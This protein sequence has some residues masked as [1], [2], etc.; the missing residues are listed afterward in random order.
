MWDSHPFSGDLEGSGRTARASRPVCI[1]FA[2]SRNRCRD[3]GLRRR[4][5]VGVLRARGAASSSPWISRSRRTISSLR[6][7]ITL[8]SASST[9][10][11]C[12]SASKPRAAVS[13]RLSHSSA[14]VIASRSGDA[15]GV[16]LDVR[17]PFARRWCCPGESRLRAAGH[18]RRR[19]TPPLDGCDEQLE[20]VL[21]NTA[22]SFGS[23]FP[24]LSRKRN[25]HRR[26]FRRRAL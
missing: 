22:G 21:T 7:S 12:A 5:E 17:S 26:S 18:E 11:R 2:A 23:P 9:A 16:V 20:I 4:P 13:R 14:S 1:S 10:R 19:A 24:S 25:M 3:A 6:C 8:S 15:I